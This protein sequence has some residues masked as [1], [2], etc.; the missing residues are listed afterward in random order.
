MANV[1]AGSPSRGENVVVHVKDFVG[2]R[3][4]TCLGGS[5]HLHFWQNERGL[6][7]APA[8]TW[9]GTDSEQASSQ[10]VNL[11]GKKSLPAP[12]EIGTRN[13]SITSPALYQQANPVLLSYQPCFT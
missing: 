8:V 9:G 13:L 11:G 2:S 5:C 6:L 7:R 4:Y 1:P 10:K 12:A 3:V